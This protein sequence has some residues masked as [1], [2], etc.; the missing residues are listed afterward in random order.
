LVLFG[1]N[2]VNSWGN[3][4]YGQ[5][6]IGDARLPSIRGQGGNAQLVKIT[7][8][9]RIIPGLKNIQAVAAGSDHSL[10]L[11][12]QGRVYSFGRNHRG[13]LGLGH[14][15]DINTPTIIPD[16]INITAIFARYNSSF[17][18]TNQGEIY[19]FGES[20]NQRNVLFSYPQLINLQNIVA[21]SP[22]YEH[23]LY[24]DSQGLV[25][26]SGY[27]HNYQLGSTS[28]GWVGL[29]LIKHLR[30]VVGICSTRSYSF[31]LNRQGKIYLLG[32][33]G[34]RTRADQ[35]QLNILPVLVPGLNHIIFISS[36]A[37]AML[38][39]DYQGQVWK[40]D[41]INLLQ[42]LYNGKSPRLYRSNIVALQTI[43]DS[44]V[45]LDRQGELE[46]IQGNIPEKID[47]LELY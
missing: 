9:P 16:L 18:L 39:L 47:Q 38:A 5:L 28:Q 7:T 4:K 6:G 37:E 30:N 13:Q 11:D 36:T 33:N 32:D 19:E 24:L 20:L 26:G 17:A 8:K 44:I 31:F 21:V 43:G 35:D 45:L 22:G 23:C 29:T 2:Q 42:C 10:V 34:I 46:F 15:D 14:D 40:I 12:Y 3:N 25:Y 27:N 41:Y 1:P